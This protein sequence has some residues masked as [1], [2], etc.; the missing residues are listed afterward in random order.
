M[1]AF[2]EVDGSGGLIAVSPMGEYVIR[3]NTE[4]MSYAVAREGDEVI[5]GI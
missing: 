2:A 5:A 3:N 4:T 1:Q